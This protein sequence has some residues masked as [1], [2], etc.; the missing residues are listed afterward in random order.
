MKVKQFIKRNDCE[1]FVTEDGEV[2]QRNIYYKKTSG[3]WKNEQ[4]EWS[5]WRKRD[6]AKETKP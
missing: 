1:I 2:Y 3:N 6:L 5:V 4:K